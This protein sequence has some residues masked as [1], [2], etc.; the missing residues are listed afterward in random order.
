[1]VE[2]A[3][4]AIVGIGNPRGVMATAEAHERADFVVMDARRF[5][6]QNIVEIG[7]VHGHN[8]IEILKVPITD[9]PGTSICWDV[10]AEECLSHASVRRGSAVMADGS[11]RIDF[12]FRGSS[13]MM[14]LCP[15]DVLG[16]GR[17]ADIAEANKQNSV[18]AARGRHDRIDYFTMM[19]FNLNSLLSS[20][21][22]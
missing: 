2:T 8:Q 4:A 1:M 14:G 20:R 7:F 19:R 21:T 13:C 5:Q 17:A 3:L 11:S 10:F 15:K 9:L 22:N 16:C 6:A 12:E 18:R